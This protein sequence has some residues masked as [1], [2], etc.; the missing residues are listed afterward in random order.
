[1]QAIDLQ[2][3]QSEERAF[4]RPSGRDDRAAEATERPKR[5]GSR[6]G[7]GMGVWRPSGRGGQAERPGAWVAAEQPSEGGDRAAVVARV[8]AGSLHPP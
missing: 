2:I 5:P 6:V 1:M 7:S 3:S 4:V 8:A